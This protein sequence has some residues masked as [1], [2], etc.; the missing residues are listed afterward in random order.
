MGKSKTPKLPISPNL[1]LSDVDGG[2]CTS[3]VGN[4]RRF[5]YNDS[6][7]VCQSAKICHR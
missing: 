4:K 6:D 7:E 3:A 1:S 2:S 5:I